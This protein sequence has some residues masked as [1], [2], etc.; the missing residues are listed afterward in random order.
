MQ[1]GFIRQQILENNVPA[2]NDVFD[3]A[4][5]LNE[6][7]KNA[8][9]YDLAQNPR[10]SDYKA[11]SCSSQETKDEELCQAVVCASSGRS[12]KCTNSASLG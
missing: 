3:K 8:S 11:A 9:L 10:S 2:L 1:S 7:R 4:R 5:R 12:S 6:A